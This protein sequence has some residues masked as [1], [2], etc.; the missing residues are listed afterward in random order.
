MP[1]IVRD[2][3][4]SYASE[5]LSNEGISDVDSYESFRKQIINVLSLFSFTPSIDF[6]GEIKNSDIE[7]AKHILS[8][9]PFLYLNEKDQI[10]FL[11]FIF[12]KKK[13]D[14]SKFIANVNKIRVD[15]I[16][17]SNTKFKERRNLFKEFSVTETESK[18]QSYAQDLRSINR[19]IIRG[20]N[21]FSDELIQELISLFKLLR[22]EHLYSNLS[23]AADLISDVCLQI[24]N[25][26]ILTLFIFD[27]N[28]V[29]YLLSALLEYMDL[30]K[31]KM[32]KQTVFGRADNQELDYTNVVG[33]FAAFMDLRNE[34]GQY[35]DILDLLKLEAES[36]P[37]EF[38]NPLDVYRT[39][40]S[41]IVKDG[42]EDILTEGNPVY[43]YER[44]LDNTKMMIDY[45]YKFGGRNADVANVMDLKV[46]FREFYISGAGY[47]NQAQTIVRKFIK[48]FN[49][50]ND[51]NSFKR[52]SEYMFLREKI[53][54]GYFRETIGLK[55][56]YEKN[57]LQEAVYCNLLWIFLT[58]DYDHIY[59]SLLDFLSGFI[60]VYRS[61]IGE[62]FISFFKKSI[63]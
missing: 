33:V 20:G 27:D 5:R 2:N 18:H 45:F 59:E 34:Y 44:K 23:L 61:Y 62:N 22:D 57:T 55:R 31:V 40:K 19:R 15:F 38:T 48:K 49:E 8:C 17:D 21:I 46:Y 63:P 13:N 32:I 16:N 29:D 50:S 60:N 3:V 14:S 47:R 54:R 42:L 58:F 39:T 43:D 6:F 30:H 10:K 36:E 1:S 9:F 12:D 51:T 53:S 28:D 37:S 7:L 11:D 56:Y 4:N 41:M 25:Y 52:F 26:W 35:I 24:L